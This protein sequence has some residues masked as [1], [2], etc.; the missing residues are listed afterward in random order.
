MALAGVALSMGPVSAQEPDEQRRPAPADVHEHVAVSATALT[1]S[2]ET[3]GTAWLPAATPMYGVHRPWRDW[4]L[5]LDGAAFAEFLYEP[6]D[7]HRTGGAAR[8]Q[9]GSVNW[10]MV[11]AR[12]AIGAGRFGIRTMVSAEPWTVSGCGSLNLFATGEVCDNDTIHDRQQ[13]HDAGMEIAG[14]YEQPLGRVWRWQVYAAL[15]GEPALGPPAY[16][17]RPSATANPIAPA[18]HHWFDG[19]QSTFGV[20]TVAMHNQR[21]KAETSVFNGRDPDENRGDLDLGAFDS[22]AA[23]VSFLPT[24]RVALQASIGRLQEART[25]FLESSPQAAT[26]LTASAIYHRPLDAGVWATTV[27]VG[28]HVARETIGAARVRQNT[29]A[30]MA[31]SSVAVAEAHSLFGR[32]ELFEMSAHHLHAS[33]FDAAVFTMGK[34]QLGYVRHF[35]ALRGVVPGLGAT[36][37]VSVVPAALAP[38]Y[39]GRA[40]PGFGVFFMVRPARHAM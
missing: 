10:L 30:V 34:L 13:P 27:A 25:E 24:E 19:S 9:F 23:R 1:P 35:S 12:R 15:A 32:V 20:V 3:S 31:E 39:G 21:W 18:T 2:R 37:S 5:R 28:S 17:H 40:A 14:D 38:R 8:R 22:V 36:A 11:M 33:E 29:W 26:K 7:R 16:S 4:D 6:N